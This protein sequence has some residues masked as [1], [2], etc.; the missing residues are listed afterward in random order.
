MLFS[1]VLILS[2]L[3]GHYTDNIPDRGVT[4]G[5]S[6]WACRVQI[7]NRKHV[8]QTMGVEF[9]HLS[10]WPLKVQLEKLLSCV[11]GNAGSDIFDT[12]PIQLK[13]SQF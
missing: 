2:K 10:V 6:T 4:K 8:V 1:N 3:L 12:L 5:F 9:G 7:H 13:V 11:I